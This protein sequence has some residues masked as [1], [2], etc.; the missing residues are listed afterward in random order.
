MEKKRNCSSRAV[1]PLIHDI[2]HLMLNF[3]FITR[4][5]LSL[6]DKRLFEITEVEI[7]RVDCIYNKMV[8]HIDLDVVCGHVLLFLLDIKIENTVELQ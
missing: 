6:R 8:M 3:C 1:S 4:I 5:R 7:A 2:F